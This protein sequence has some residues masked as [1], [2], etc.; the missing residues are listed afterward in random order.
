[1]KKYRNLRKDETGIYLGGDG[2]E[3]FH[4][5][6]E[7]HILLFGPNGSGKDTSIITP[8]LANCR[9]SIFVIDPEGE[10]AAITAR[11]RSTFSRIVCINPF[12]VFVSTHPILKSVG[13]NWLFWLDPGSPDF[14][15]RCVEI[16]Q[17]IVKIDP[18]D[19]QKYF[20]ESARALLAALII[21]V[22]LTRKKEA[23]LADV[24]DMLCAPMG[25]DA[26]GHPIG[27]SKTIADIIAWADRSPNEP[28]VQAARNK[29]G[30]FAKMTRGL[31]DVQGSART[32]T[33]FLDSVPIRKD[34][35]R[36]GLDF[37]SMKDA[38]I[39]VY[40]IMPHL[41]K[42]AT[43]LRVLM[44]AVLQAM[45]RTPPN[46]AMPRPLL[47]FNE[48]AQAGH[49]ELLVN[50]HGRAR[51]WYQILSCWQSLNQIKTH[52]E[53][54]M[55]TFIGARGLLTSFAPQDME[56]A[57]YLSDLCGQ[58][59]EVVASRNFKPED[60]TGSSSES[61]QSFSLVRPEDLM[62]L[63]R[64]QTL[65]FVE[66]IKFPFLAEAP[67]HFELDHCKGLD[68]NPYHPAPTA[69]ATVSG[70]R[71]KLDNLIKRRT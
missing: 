61:V 67:A 39:T 62:R 2:N 5:R 42:H 33:D 11:W 20:A 21:W 27:L 28:L 7:R 24:R 52:Y 22:I 46:P 44:S 69:N 13:F 23:S 35:S 17:S 3:A 45:M 14:I 16:A 30:H 40:L 66:G 25:E 36:E 38:I 56:T 64:A 8:I 70:T 53:K 47:L 29:I 55:D 48:A 19:P 58:Y 15:D 43:W 41:D 68:R 34:M 10:Q 18:R 6:G 57:K 71:S 9:R 65:N 49:L 51:K 60:P 50:A 1:M 4:Y 54:S 32:A 31:I 37:A 63:D 26:E 59:G 12:D